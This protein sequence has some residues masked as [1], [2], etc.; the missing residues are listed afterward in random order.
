MSGYTR[1][2]QLEREIASRIADGT[3]KPGEKIMSETELA[4]RFN[5]SRGTVRRALEML[6]QRRLIET[7]PGSGSYVAFH[8]RDLEDGDGWT[9]ASVS[10]GVP[11]STKVL[12]I[13]LVERPVELADEPAESDMFYKV[14]RCRMF[15]SMPISHETS[16]LPATRAMREVMDGG[17]VEGS[18]SRTMRAAGMSP[19]S[20]SVD[21]SAERLGEEVGEAMGQS[22]QTVFL[23]SERKSYGAGGTLVEYVRSYLDPGHFTMHISIGGRQ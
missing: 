1:T 19:F 5:V 20:G 4:E 6:K 18:V 10:S 15:H 9:S 22:P 17:L 11:T 14:E 12:S 7:R 13:A 23:M 3:L 21:V 16:Y 8:G 2:E